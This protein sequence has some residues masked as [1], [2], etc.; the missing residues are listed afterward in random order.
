MCDIVMNNEKER[1]NILGGI[2]FMNDAQSEF[3]NIPPS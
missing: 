1:A 3:S 2:A